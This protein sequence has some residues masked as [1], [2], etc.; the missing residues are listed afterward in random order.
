MAKTKFNEIYDEES[1]GGFKMSPKKIGI[2]IVV[3]LLAI[4]S[5]VVFETLVGYNR[6]SQWQVIQP[7]SGEA[8][9][10]DQSGYYYKGFATVYDW[11]RAYT[12]VY[13]D[14]EGEGEENSEAISVTFNDGG[15]AAQATMIRFALPTD[16]ALRIK[17]HKDFN[18][19]MN[20]VIMAVKSHMI[21]CCKAAAPLMSSSENQSARKA[22]FQQVVEEMMKK[23][24][25]VMKRVDRELKDRTDE[26][27]KAITV[28]ATEIVL[29]KNNQ[30]TIAQ[31]S[32]LADYGIEIMQFSVTGTEYDEQTRKQFAQKKESF[33]K[34]EQSKAQ[35]ESEVQERL[36]I[37]EKYKKEKS[38]T[39]G[40]A[41][42]EMAKAEIEGKQKVAVAAQAK[43]EAETLAQQKVA[44][45]QQTKLEAE[46]KANQL[47]E[48]AKIN[49]KEAETLAEQRLAVASLEAQAAIKDA[50]AIVTL[51]KAQEEKI[52]LAGAITEKERVLAQINADMKAQIAESLSKMKVPSTVFM[53]G[54]S[55]GSGSYTD[56]LLTI[57]L[58]KQAGIINTEAPVG[59]VNTTK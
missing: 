49:K 41:N 54:G 5:I 45:A 12:Q 22:E 21:T 38:E 33:L 35:R 16:P 3:V 7:M 2:L 56:T 17:L 50:E 31:A 52:K 11:P 8:Y 55:G 27:G 19:S 36:M 43:L 6:L 51:A 9:T 34:A 15:I 46:M 18:G 20:N 42:K 59:P 10:R 14:I 28:Y 37:E 48:V 47:L 26:K 1:V 57:M 24:L 58:G 4:V 23:G 30:P 53:G 39:E 44:V 13:N 32:P 40:I 29:D 25:Y